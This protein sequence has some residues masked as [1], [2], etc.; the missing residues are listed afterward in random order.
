[1]SFLSAVMKQA[2]PRKGSKRLDLHVRLGV[3]A[4]GAQRRCQE[5]WV[6]ITREAGLRRCCSLTYRGPGVPQT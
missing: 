6:R 1:M 2:G 5:R 4:P 3:C